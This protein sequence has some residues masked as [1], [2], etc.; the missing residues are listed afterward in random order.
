MTG[1][2][3]PNIPTIGEPNSTEDVDIREGMI[4][5]RDGLNAILGASNKVEAFEESKI[6][7]K[8]IKNETIKAEDLEKNTLHFKVYAP[9]VIAGPHSTESTS[10][11]F[12]TEEDKIEGIEVATGAIVMLLYDATWEDNSGAIARAA[13]FVGANQ[14]K[15][16]AGNGAY[17]VVE[18]RNNGLPNRKLPLLS[19]SIGLVGA[20]T[21]GETEGEV[22]PTTGVAMAN[23]EKGLYAVN[24][25][26][27]EVAAPMPG[28][29]CFIRHLPAGTYAIGVKFKAN[30]AGK[31][32]ARERRLIIATIG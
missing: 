10:Y 16:V 23:I 20:E 2:L 12:L 11:V 18:A 32:T 24:G 13:V 4:I 31:V 17:S 6:E 19:H 9:K 15:A 22:P 8:H 25:T 21:N 30:T 7:S 1:T 5:L 26:N 28:N 14:L 29:A 27:K 3:N